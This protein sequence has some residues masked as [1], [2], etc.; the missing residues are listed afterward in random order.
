M[1][2]TQQQSLASG[3]PSQSGD[4][5]ETATEGEKASA[6]VA[7][8]RVDE[9]APQPADAD[10]DSGNPPGRDR[11]I[12]RGMASPGAASQA[13]ASARHATENLPE[14]ERRERH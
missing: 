1:K 14:R 7:S 9:T 4:L 2:E 13:E 3:A 11:S 5:G 10:D 8:D 6:A 12:D